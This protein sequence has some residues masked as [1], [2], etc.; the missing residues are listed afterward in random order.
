MKH[1][2]ALAILAIIQTGCTQ[3][4]SESATEESSA[5]SESSTNAEIAFEEKTFDF[6]QINEG[7]VVSHSFKFKNVGTDPLNILSV[8]V[9]CGCTVASK[10]EQPVGVGQSDEIVINFN[11]KGKVGENH[12]T[13]TVMSNAK[14][15]SERLEFTASVKAIEAE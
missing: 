5:M 2:V 7:E 9:S 6:G 4:S 8:N 14:N 3:A 12:K 1:L 10:P 11:S 15:S 13:V